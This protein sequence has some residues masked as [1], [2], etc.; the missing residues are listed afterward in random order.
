MTAPVGARLPHCP[1]ISGST[2]AKTISPMIWKKQQG[3][4]VPEGR[5]KVAGGGASAARE[6][7]GTCRHTAVRPGGA[8][9]GAAALVSATAKKVS[10]APPGRRAG[11]GAESRWLR[12][13][14]APPPAN[15]SGPSGAA[16]APPAQP[17][18]A[19]PGPGESGRKLGFLPGKMESHVEVQGPVPYQSGASPQNRPKKAA[20]G[21]RPGLSMPMSARPGLL[22]GIGRAFSPLPRWVAD[23]R[24]DAPVCYGPGLWPLSRWG[25]AA[26]ALRSLLSGWRASGEWKPHFYAQALA[27]SRCRRE[28]GLKTPETAIC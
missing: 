19:T 9:E 13:C 11:L 4:S 14:L 2:N 22:F 6:T 7:P 25:G 20:K 27:R 24:G 3:G 12:S 17:G 28:F 8:R 26:S 10:P 1:G 15:F 23:H 21:Q 18:P 5:K 16:P